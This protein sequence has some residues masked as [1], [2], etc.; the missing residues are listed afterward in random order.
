MKKQPSTPGN[1]PFYISIIPITRL[2]QQDNR[3]KLL[4]NFKGNQTLFVFISLLEFSERNR[5]LES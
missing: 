1:K 4:F 3:Q 5:G 2:K